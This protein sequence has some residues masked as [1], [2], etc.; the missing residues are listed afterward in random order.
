[1]RA[2]ASIL[3]LNREL[4]V[5]AKWQRLPAGVNAVR[6][7]EA[8]GWLSL[9]VQCRA[10][11]GPAPRVQQGERPRQSRVKAASIALRRATCIQGKQNEMPACGAF[12][13][14]RK[15]FWIQAK[16]GCLNSSVGDMRMGSRNNLRNRQS[17]R[18]I[19]TGRANLAWEFTLGLDRRR[20]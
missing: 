8:V 5:E 2:D 17:P 11:K 6:T 18:D 14:H 9:S 3:S 15:E 20:S 16:D 19:P 12:R 4:R 1:M 13:A 7:R 10:G